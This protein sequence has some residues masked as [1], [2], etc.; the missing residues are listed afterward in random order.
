LTQLI[1][2]TAEPLGLPR[3]SVRAILAIIL[4]IALI[5]SVLA[6]IGQPAVAPGAVLLAQLDLIVIRDYF[7]KRSQEPP[8]T[9]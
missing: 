7:E 6:T 1:N 4:T 8:A 5:A 9:A 2:P 3:G